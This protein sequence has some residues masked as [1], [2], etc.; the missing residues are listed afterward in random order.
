VK[1]DVESLR[2][3]RSSWQDQEYLEVV[4]SM[5]FTLLD[6]FVPA[7]TEAVIMIEGGRPQIR[8]ESG[9]ILAAFLPNDRAARYLKVSQ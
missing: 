7:G 5:G 3:R 1:P 8:S 9:E 6:C 2:L 4:N